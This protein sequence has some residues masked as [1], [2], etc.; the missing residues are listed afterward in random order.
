MQNTGLGM[1]DLSIIPYKCQTINSVSQFDHLHCVARLTLGLAV[2]KRAET[3]ACDMTLF[4][5][6]LH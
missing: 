2:S 4:F 6:C 5:L 3:G 1:I